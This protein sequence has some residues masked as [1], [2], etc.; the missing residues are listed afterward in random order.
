VVESLLFEGVFAILCGFDVVNLWCSC[1]DLRGGRGVLA[2]MFSTA[3]NTPL[4]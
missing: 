3:K 2:A 1:G 4:F